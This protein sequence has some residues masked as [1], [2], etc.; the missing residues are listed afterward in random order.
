M[1]FDNKMQSG[2]LDPTEM[3]RMIERTIKAKVKI[4]IHDK[5]SRPVHQV[6]VQCIKQKFN[7]TETTF[8]DP[9]SLQ[10]LKI[11][12]RDYN[13]GYLGSTLEVLQDFKKNFFALTCSSLGVTAGFSN[14]PSPY[15]VGSWTLLLTV[16]TLGSLAIGLSLEMPNRKAGIE[17]LV[18]IFLEQGYHIKERRIS[19]VFILSTFLLMGIVLS[20]GYKS[21]VTSSVVKPF[22]KARIKSFT[23]A[24]Q[25]NYKMIVDSNQYRLKG[26]KNTSVR[27]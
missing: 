8:P 12:T 13:L 11:H 16:V 14:F 21:V 5:D 1:E 19:L 27:E 2:K 10:A 3:D 15:D 20:N 24:I 17:T 25:E 9:I 4:Y 22:Q 7:Q 18:S 6:L 23:E 26:L